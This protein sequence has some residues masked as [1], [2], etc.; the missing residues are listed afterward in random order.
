MYMVMKIIFC[1]TQIKL[2]FHCSQNLISSS[3]RSSSNRES[4]VDHWSFWSIS[5][6]FSFLELVSSW[7]VKLSQDNGQL[8]WK[9]F[10]AILATLLCSLCYCIDFDWNSLR[11]PV[12]VC[13]NNILQSF[14]LLRTNADVIF[15]TIIV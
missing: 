14:I 10:M 8:L 5:F 12:A 2:F 11:D 3:P 6:F 1:S 15:I 7:K 9:G 4:A 13:K